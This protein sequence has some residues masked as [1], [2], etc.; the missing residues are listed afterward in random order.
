MYYLLL[1]LFAQH[2]AQVQARE[3]RNRFIYKNPVF[4]EAPQHPTRQPP[5]QGAVPVREHYVGTAIHL[6]TPSQ[7]LCRWY[8]N[9]Y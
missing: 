3:C 5:T 2:R 6:S 1:E 4:G 8:T 7:P 9:G